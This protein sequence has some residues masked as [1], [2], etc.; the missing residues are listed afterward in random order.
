MLPWAQGQALRGPAKYLRWANGQCPRPAQ[1]GPHPMG[2]SAQS[3]LPQLALS[4]PQPSAPF[5]WLQSSPV[6]QVRWLPTK[7]ST[8]VTLLGMCCCAWGPG[9]PWGPQCLGHRPQRLQGVARAM[10]GPGWV[11]LLIHL[12]LQ[13]PAW[14][15]LGPQEPVPCP[16]WLQQQD[17]RSASVCPASRLPATGSGRSSELLPYCPWPAA[18]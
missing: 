6:L 4:G 9:L 16:T 7:E 13:C 1:G 5:T 11:L 10:L 8:E 2:C 3:P 15:P 14:L 12:G 17:S 18:G